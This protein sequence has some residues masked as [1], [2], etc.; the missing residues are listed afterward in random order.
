VKWFGETGFVSHVATS[1]VAMTR[2]GM[3][4]Q[5]ANDGMLHAFDATTGDEKWAY[6]P[7]MV[8]PTL[9][10]YTRRVS[11]QHTYYVDGTPATSEVSDGAG[12]WKTILVGGL[13]KG[14]RGVYALDITNPAAATEADVAAKVLWEFPNTATSSYAANVGYSF[15]KPI[16]AKTRSGQWVVLV[17]SGY[18]NGSDTSG[19]GKGHLFVLN[20]LTG[21]VIADITAATGAENA[22][23]GTSA[24]P[25]GLAQLT[26]FVRNYDR[27]PILEYVYGG[28]LKG[29]V[30]RFD[31]SSPTTSN[32]KMLKLAKLVD[33]SGNFQP[34]TTAPQL[35]VV[36]DKPLIAV[37]TGQYLGKSDIVGTGTTPNAHASQTQS[38]YGLWDDLSATPRIDAGGVSVR[39]KLLQRSVSSGATQ[40]EIA[41]TAPDTAATSPYDSGKRGWLFNFT[42][43]GERLAVAPQLALGTL[44]FPTNTPSGIICT[45]GGKTWLY[46]VD[47]QTGLTYS[48][49]SATTLKVEYLGDALT[50]RASLLSLSPGTVRA[51]FRTGDI[52]V[53]PGSTTVSTTVTTSS[54]S[55]GGGTGGP[56]NTTTTT[57]L[58]NGKI[59]TTNT[60]NADGTMVGSSSG[61]DVP[62][63]TTAPTVSRKSWREVPR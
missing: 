28:D 26:A 22:D 53:P 23:D 42:L 37:G 9:N 20:A 38:M 15:G 47:I 60:T 57:V 55:G 34:V 48:G 31:L 13:G 33:A 52:V 29:N 5:G 56:G 43:S 32:W 6:V 54:S 27:N 21:A 59:T 18:N 44:V 16:I 17:S 7:S 8:L 10:K 14:G 2:P 35:T 36:K 12:N 11:F 24:S 62:R 51:V 40:R 4:Y 45:A 19:D 39:T 49:P 58:T 61:S 25:S 63:R 1:S 30:W 46:Y 50:S 41:P 3:V